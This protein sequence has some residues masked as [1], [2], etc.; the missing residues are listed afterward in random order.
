VLLSNIETMSE[1][2]VR[3][4]S[5]NERIHDAQQQLEM[6]LRRERR[7]D[8]HAAALDRAEFMMSVHH[9]RRRAE[10]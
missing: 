6:E 3:Q 7:E 10:I 8:E 1:L 5:H 9:A 2:P 4:Y